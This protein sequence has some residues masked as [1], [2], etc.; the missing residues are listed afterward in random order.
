VRADGL[1]F[2]L[3]IRALS[4]VF[5]GKFVAEL[6]ILHAAGKLGFLW[7]IDAAGGAGRVCRYAADALP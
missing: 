1:G 3:P 7:R 6:R 5:R 2:F 4:L